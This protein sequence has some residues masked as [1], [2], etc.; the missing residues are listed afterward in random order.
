LS[1]A[2]AVA[3]GGSFLGWKV[4]GRAKGGDW[5]VLYVDGEMHIAD[6]QERARLLLD[7]VPDIDR[8]KVGT[9]HSPGSRSMS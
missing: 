4:G 9:N 2:I 8:S 7:A 1:A 6:I 5:R 3:G